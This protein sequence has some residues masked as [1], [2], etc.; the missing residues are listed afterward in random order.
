M[1]HLVKGRTLE[2]ALT[3]TPEAVAEE[4]G[5]LPEDHTHCAALAVNTLGEAIDAFYQTQW[6]NR[7]TPQQQG[8]ETPCPSTR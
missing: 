1:T 6:G 2:K 5:G 3:L 7:H 8:D 4:L